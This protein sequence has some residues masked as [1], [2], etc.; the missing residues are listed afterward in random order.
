[1]F[2][3]ERSKIGSG[4]DIAAGGDHALTAHEQLLHELEA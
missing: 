2:E 4:G 3:R 1:M